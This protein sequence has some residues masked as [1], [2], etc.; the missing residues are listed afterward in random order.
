MSRYAIDRDDLSLENI[1]P[2]QVI[3]SYNKLCNLL[4]IKAKQGG[5]TRIAQRKELERYINFENISRNKII[6]N[7]I[8]LIPQ[9]KIDKRIE[10]NNAVYRDYFIA[11]LISILRKCK[12][13]YLLCSRGY[14]IEQ[15]GFVNK[16]YRNCRSN[17]KET[18][19]ELK[20]PEEYLLDFYMINNTKLIKN[21]ESNIAYFERK[22]Y[23]IAD[24][25]TAVCIKNG[26]KEIHRVA[27]EDEKELIIKCENE[28]KFK[29]GIQDS[30]EIFYKQLWTVFNSNVKQ[31]L[32]D[33]GSN[34][35][36]YYKAYNFSIHKDTIEQLYNSLV[37]KEN[38]TL[39]KI[40][41]EI[42]AK[43]KESALNSLDSRKNNAE[44]RL[45]DGKGGKY[46]RE[47]DLLI[48]N[49]KFEKH[50]KKMINNLIS[51][52]ANSIQINFFED[53]IPFETSDID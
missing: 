44:K 42:N 36:Y 39:G 19:K 49:E 8:Y 52:N 40:K 1:S 16:N 24:Q 34:I 9:P 35:C 43:Y 29:L 53:E 38:S 3:E 14:L 47:R 30:A 37:K 6:I 5:D 31:K 51:G 7:E 10:G 12:K 13:N 33:E 45:Q 46:S 2:G 20:I 11:G 41:K 4:G 17:P 21:I 18:A 23:Y 15:L 50:G 22:S 32:K 25:V 26:S 28:V 27:T 48:T